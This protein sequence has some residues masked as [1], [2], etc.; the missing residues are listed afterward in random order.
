MSVPLPKFGKYY[1]AKGWRIF[2]CVVAPLLIA[3]FV[4]IPLVWWLEKPMPLL[5][6]LYC[7]I[8]LS[9]ALLFLYGLAEAAGGHII[10][11]PESITERRVLGRRQLAWVE[12]K[13]Y[14]IGKN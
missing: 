10:I 6:A 2:M 5:T 8:P 14:R 12:I 4:G 1:L 11:T 3:L 9:F 13:G 7:L